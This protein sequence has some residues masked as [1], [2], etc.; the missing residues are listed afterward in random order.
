MGEA[1]DYDLA[2][3]GLYTRTHRAQ[4]VPAGTSAE[5]IDARPI[6]LSLIDRIRA[7]VPDCRD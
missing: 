4:N 5:G 2:L 7:Q 6:D 3:V 1:M